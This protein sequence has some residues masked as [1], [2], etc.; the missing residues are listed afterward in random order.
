[1]KKA[2]LCPYDG[3]TPF[4]DVG[5]FVECPVTA[6][7]GIPTGPRNA[8]CLPNAAINSLG[9]DPSVLSQ[10]GPCDDASRCVPDLFAGYMLTKLPK[11]CRSLRGPDG[12]PVE[13]RCMS[14]CL[15]QVQDMAAMLPATSN[16]ECDDATE[17]CAPCF[18]PRNGTPLPTCTLGEGQNGG[19]CDTPKEKVA[20]WQKCC[21][22]GGTCLPLEVI[23]LGQAETLGQKECPDS[24]KC[25]P[26]VA[27]DDPS[28]KP[29]E[30]RTGGGPLGIFSTDGRCVPDCA[31]DTTGI[32][33][34]LKTLTLTRGEEEDGF[35][36]CA[37]DEKCAPCQNL[38]SD[39]GAC[40]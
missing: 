35:T 31:I 29:R 15:T 3:D 30:C 28:W 14:R 26:Q 40:F 12:N 37:E 27:V 21:N 8:H 16:G 32:G 25:A 33:G 22:N 23:P 24:Y 36:I 10:L 38:G 7:P 34:V 39:T 20:A 19:T 9:V 2:P 5:A 13:G 4:L 18:D 6:C 1:V 17:A 11:T